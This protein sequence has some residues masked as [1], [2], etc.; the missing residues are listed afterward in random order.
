[1]IGALVARVVL[2]LLATVVIASSLTYIL[3][4]GLTGALRD[5]I[6]PETER[7]QRA[8]RALE[9]KRP[10][11]DANLP[12]PGSWISQAAAR[13]WR[14]ARTV[15]AIALA[16]AV[17]VALSR[18]RARRRRRYVRYRLVPYRSDEAG[19]IDVRRLLEAWHQQL[20][21]RWWRRVAFGQRS[22]A[23]EISL[24]PDSARG[25]VRLSLVA[26]DDDSLRRGIEGSLSSCYPDLRIVRT[27]GKPPWVRRVVRLKKR[28]NFTLRLST[29]E[30]L[31]GRGSEPA[32]IDNLCETLGALG[33]GATVQYSLVPTPAM[34]DRFARW[35]FKSREEDLNRKA[36][37]RETDPGRSSEIAEQELEGGLLVQHRPLFFC[38][39]RVGTQRFGT[40]EQIAGSLRG[41]SGSENR[42]VERRMLARGALYEHRMAQGLANP[43]P[44]WRRGVFSSSELCG[45]WHLPSHSLKGIRIERSQVP[46]VPAPPEIARPAPE[47]ALC[48]DERG[49][50][51]IRDADKYL[52]VML[53]GAQGMGKTSVMCASIRDDLQDPNC[54]MFV[55]DPKEDLARKALSWVPPERTVHYVDFSSPEVGFDPFLADGNP[56][57]VADGIVEAFKDVHEE[58]AIQASSDRFLRQS[59]LAA[60]NYYGTGKEGRHGDGGAT[61][62]D[63]WQMLLPNEVELRQVISSTEDM[64]RELPATMMYF[65]RQLPEQLAQSRT[66]MVARLDA[67]VNKLQRI[68]AERTLDALLRHPVTVSIDEVIRKREVLIVNGALGQFGEGNVRVL[69]QFLLHMIHR[70]IVRQQKLPEPE[71]ARVALKVDEAHL[72]FSKTFA[73]MLAMD[74][75]AGLECMAAWQSL[76]QIDDPEVRRT[77]LDLLRHRCLF[78]L[79]EESAR[80][81]SAMLQPIYTDSFREDDKSRQR[82]RLPPDVLL[83]MPKYWCA[84]S[85]MSKGS[86]A[87]SFVAQTM[88]MRED[89]Q[90]IEHHLEAQ[91]ARGAFLPGRVDPPE[92]TM[93]PQ[94]ERVR[95]LQGDDGRAEVVEP[96]D[97]QASGEG[98]HANSRR[99]PPDHADGEGKASAG[100]ETTNGAA[101]VK[102][103]EAVKIEPF[104]PEDAPSSPTKRADVAPL[105]SES[106]QGAPESFTE[107]DFDD[108]IGLRWDKPAPG[109]PDK[110]KPPTERQV[111]I[112]A[113]LYELGYLYAPQ[114]Y[115]RFIRDYTERVQQREMKTILSAGW[116]RRCEIIRER[117][118]RDFRVYGLTKEGFEVLRSYRGPRGSYV[119]EGAEF[120]MP[121]MNDPRRLLHDLHA[122]GWLLAAQQLLGK[123]MRSYRGP[124]HDPLEPPAIREVGGK[125]R[126]MEP[127]EVPLGSGQFVDGLKADRFSTLRPDL[128][129]EVAYPAP[130]SR[131]LD[132]LIEVDRTGRPSQNIR[133]F[134]RYDAMLT[135]WG[136]ALDRY[137]LLGE[138]PIAI[139]VCEDEHKALEFAA[140]ADPEVTGRI[141]TGGQESEEML[142]PGRQRMFFVAEG[143]I[144]G[145]STR[146]YRLAACPPDVRRKLMTTRKREVKAE[147]EQVTLVPQKLLERK[148]QD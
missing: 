60:I 19:A 59:A 102:Q 25:R 91:R 54:A 125:W 96:V 78:A 16:V 82:H 118:R 50:V 124:M 15:L 119:R 97:A 40:C 85:W 52:G 55:F 48:R 42:L 103:R 87:A 39:V 104:R 129:L 132:W 57:A 73:R 116:V 20:L 98:E 27:E 146:A 76:G 89:P 34:F 121:E 80:E 43:L 51:A 67:P 83:N 144:H 138:P 143:D 28:G 35:R 33:E 62:W 108:A 13:A 114:I 68:V 9:A 145:G 79:S 101:G 53:L 126:T 58:G 71:R 134:H 100:R 92:R 61:F 120:R 21:E 142:Y 65:Q 32:L 84:C 18:W 29:P 72:L 44:P 106:P 2:G 86:R 41:S 127:N 148:R 37:H 22:L 95:R 128:R 77:I 123:L 133:K 64:A 93:K 136:R 105:G 130:Y 31:E 113:M 10:T 122:N 111:E 88:P 45:L 81:L 63:M 38:D 99:P 1:M 139:F 137:Q 117:K 17:V 14:I 75:S 69:M 6:R 110:A 109:P 107:L 36:K 11:P 66:Q 135:A 70:A 115:R 49:E 47:R 56:S 26:P 3:G 7:A 140:A 5:S 147:P 30:E 94:S 24:V 4:G 131:R 23:L 112:L 12:D 90:R 8:E 46:R 141:V 74:R